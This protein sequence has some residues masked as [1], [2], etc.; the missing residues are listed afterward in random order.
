MISSLVVLCLHLTHVH[1]YNN[2]TCIHMYASMLTSHTHT[3]TTNIATY[4][5][6]KHI[7]ACVYTK[8]SIVDQAINQF[9]FSF[10]VHVLESNND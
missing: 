9:Q 1:R 10:C 7:I 5:L 6:C 8:L 3:H 2:G 4:L